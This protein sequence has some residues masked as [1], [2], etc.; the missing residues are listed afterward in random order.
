MSPLSVVELRALGP[1]G[2]LSRGSFGFAE[3]E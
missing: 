2:E 3:G 1:R